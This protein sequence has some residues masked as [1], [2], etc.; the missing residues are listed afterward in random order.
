MKTCL[1]VAMIGSAPAFLVTC[2][3]G[4]VLSASATRNAPIIS[5][6]APASLDAAGTQP[7][8]QPAPIPYP[9]VSG[10]RG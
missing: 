3:L 1:K 9:A 2:G 8:T 5:R 4:A 7:S 10:F 6:I